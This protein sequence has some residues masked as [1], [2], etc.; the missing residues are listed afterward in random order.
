MIWRDKNENNDHTDF[1]AWLESQKV[2]AKLPKN[3][4]FSCNKTYY[5]LALP[6]SLIRNSWA[7]L[8]NDYP[9]ETAQ[10]EP[11]ENCQYVL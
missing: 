4:I 3:R 8:N 11:P 9:Q 1:L 6:T 10:L 2:D 7:S 5:Y